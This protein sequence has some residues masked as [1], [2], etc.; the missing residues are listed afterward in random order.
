METYEVSWSSRTSRT[1]SVQANSVEE[2][3]ELSRYKMEGVG[4]KG[5]GFRLNEEGEVVGDGLTEEVEEFES[6][7]DS[8]WLEWAIVDSVHGENMHLHGPGGGGRLKEPELSELAPL[9]RVDA[10]LETV[11]SKEKEVNALKKIVERERQRYDSLFKVAHKV[12]EECIV[13]EWCKDTPQFHSFIMKSTEVVGN[14]GREE[15]RYI[16]E[17]LK[18]N[19][20]DITMSERQPKWETEGIQLQAALDAFKWSIEYLDWKPLD[21]LYPGRRAN[22]YCL[23]PH[24]GK[25][26]SRIRHLW[27]EKTLNQHYPLFREGNWTSH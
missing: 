22:L 4:V 14:R 21:T 3:I 7:P 25:V 1:N 18:E 8:E 24:Q 5:D 23:S 26:S 17:E 27:G 11:A 2:A 9:D 6:I 16:V 19:L 13:D 12:E 15:L 20:W 10:L